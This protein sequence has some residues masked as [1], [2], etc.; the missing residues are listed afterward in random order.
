MTQKSGKIDVDQVRTKW[1]EI[2]K[3]MRPHNHSLE[4][5]LRS[6][7]PYGFEGN[8]LVLNVFYQFHKDR[9]EVDRH[10]KLVEE[11]VSAALNQPVRIKYL[12]A[13]KSDNLMKVVDNDIIK[14]AEE[15]FGAGEVN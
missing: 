6:C 12:L 4:A 14:T 5:L 8:Y 2:L 13:T 10:K 7:S 1:Q 15:I 9:L 11:V 3:A